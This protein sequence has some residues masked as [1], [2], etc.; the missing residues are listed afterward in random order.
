MQHKAHGY[1]G[2]ICGMDRACYETPEWLEKAYGPA[3]AGGLPSGRGADQPFYLV[4]PDVREIAT[5]AVNYVAEDMLQ[6]APKARLR[7]RLRAATRFFV[8]AF[9]RNMKREES[10]AVRAAEARRGRPPSALPALSVYSMLVA[11]CGG[12]SAGASVYIHHV[13]RS[14]RTGTLERIRYR[15]QHPLRAGQSGAD[16]CASKPCCVCEPGCSAHGVGS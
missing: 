1:F 9:L 13:P 5:V 14:G 7:R 15:L 12:Q 2:I 8:V 16:L 3:G 4:L 6:A 11:G 10:A